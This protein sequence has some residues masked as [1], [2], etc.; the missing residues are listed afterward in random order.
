MDQLFHESD[1]LIFTCAETPYVFG[2][3]STLLKWKPAHENT[4]DYKMEMIF[5]E[6]QDPDLD[7][8]IRTLHTQTMILSQ[9]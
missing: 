2:T 3:D 8:E 1:G 5:K 9:N 7:P 4:V 6:F